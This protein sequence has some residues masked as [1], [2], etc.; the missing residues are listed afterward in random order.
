MKTPVRMTMGEEEFVA[1]TLIVKCNGYIIML[2]SSQSHV[3]GVG[4]STWVPSLPTT[5]VAFGSTEK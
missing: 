5:Y 2:Y 4:T 1:L 3:L